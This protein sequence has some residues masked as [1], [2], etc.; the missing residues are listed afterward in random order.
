MKTTYA[1]VGFVA[2]GNLPYQQ[3]IDVLM[4]RLQAM[5]D[6]LSCG[7]I[8]DTPAETEMRKRMVES[9]TKL[10]T[11]IDSHIEWELVDEIVTGKHT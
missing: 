6:S 5:C 4:D 8:L 7:S 10:L 3:L 1:Q 11:R 2:D 9:I